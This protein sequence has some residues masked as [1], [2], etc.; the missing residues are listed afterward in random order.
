V[1]VD[2]GFVTIVAKAKLAAVLRKTAIGVPDPPW[3]A[4]TWPAH[5]GDALWCE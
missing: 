4:P 1:T 3:R 2:I 5:P